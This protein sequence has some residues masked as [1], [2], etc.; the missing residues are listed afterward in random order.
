MT[1]FDLGVF[2]RNSVESAATDNVMAIL[3]ADGNKPK[4]L[5]NDTRGVANIRRRRNHFTV[6]DR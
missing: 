3:R 1:C 5:G 4:R 6:F 2:V